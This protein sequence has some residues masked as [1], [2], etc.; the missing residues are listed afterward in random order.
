MICDNE[1]FYGI[2]KKLGDFDIVDFLTNK[3][4]MSFIFSLIKE[5]FIY[6]KLVLDSLFIKK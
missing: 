1:S 2:T 4:V 6:F 3:I 5:I